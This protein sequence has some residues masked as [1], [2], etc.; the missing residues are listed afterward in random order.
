M[1]A[2]N[3]ID[4][5]V[6]DELIECYG[7]RSGSPERNT[8]SWITLAT[9]AFVALSDGAFV[10]EPSFQQTETTRRGEEVSARSC[11]RAGNVRR[12]Q[13][14]GR[15]DATTNGAVVECHA[16]LESGDGLVL[17]LRAGSAADTV[18][19]HCLHM[20]L[21][22]VA[23]RGYK[24]DIVAQ[25]RRYNTSDLRQPLT[26]PSQLAALRLPVVGVETSF[27]RNRTWSDPGPTVT[28]REYVDVIAALDSDRTR[29]ALYI[30]TSPNDPLKLAFILYDRRCFVLSDVYIYSISAAPF[31]DH[32]C[33]FIARFGGIDI[34]DI[35]AVTAVVPPDGV[36]NSVSYYLQ[37]S[38][39]DFTLN[40]F[41]LH[42]ATVHTDRIFET[43]HS[44]A[45]VSAVYTTDSP[46]PRSHV[47]LLHADT[48][49]SKGRLFA[50]SRDVYHADR[51]IHQ[52]RN[53]AAVTKAPSAAGISPAMPHQ[54]A[55]LLVLSSASEDRTVGED[56]TDAPDVAAPESLR[57]LAVCVDAATDGRLWF[58]VSD[59]SAMLVGDELPPL[60]LSASVGFP[61]GFKPAGVA[62]LPCG[63][64][65]VVVGTGSQSQ[66]VYT[67]AV[68]RET[69]CALM[70]LDGDAAVS[71][72]A[73][74]ASR[75]DA[76]TACLRGQRGRFGH[77]GWKSVLVTKERML[78]AGD[79]AANAVVSAPLPLKYLRPHVL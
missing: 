34:V 26:A 2:S 22:R 5:I 19:T 41:P 24:A 65:L 78:V 66:W 39:C 67:V 18:A 73:P 50:L 37:P 43:I 17:R 69:Q 61:K 25:G 63:C 54:P 31:R 20:V 79:A 75:C 14:R 12:R 4:D 49:P 62:M 8:A 3:C 23:S 57:F 48:V 76:L 42:L 33:L 30:A 68:S 55:C 7:L 53:S 36:A 56:D 44:V 10:H 45:A 74:L 70:A 9:L 6:P 38:F 60:V 11:P 16:E 52:Y 40:A 72:I 47:T 59:P 35:G 13:I 21:P 58:I 29:V 27:E 32:D 28:I 46:Q 64:H 15:T 1:D 77:N 71:G 51:H